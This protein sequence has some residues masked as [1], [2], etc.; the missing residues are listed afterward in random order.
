MYTCV[1]CTTLS[2]ECIKIKEHP[3]SCTEHT[4]HDNYTPTKIAVI[5]KTV[6]GALAA[7]PF[8]E[9]NNLFVI[10]SNG[11]S[12][13]YAPSV[14]IALRNAFATNRKHIRKN[15][16]KHNLTSDKTCIE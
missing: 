1:W 3:A 9:A 2:T 10:P 6:I 4:Y 13:D 8:V 11:I 5:N 16:N 12:H 7:R 15:I 14:K